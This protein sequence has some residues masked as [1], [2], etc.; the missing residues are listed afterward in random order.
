MIYVSNLAAGLEKSLDDPSFLL[1]SVSAF[2]GLAG[3]EFFMHAHDAAYR[4]KMHDVKNW[5][6]D[7]PRTVHGPFITVEATS[8]KG[9][10]A[11]EHFLSS[12]LWAFEEAERLG[13]REMVFHTHQRL[14]M[15]EEKAGLQIRC[16]QN[17]QTLIEKARPYGITIL[18]ENLGIQKQG[19][20]LF[21]EDEF[22]D[23]I[24]RYP[25]AGCLIDTGHLNVAGW[26]TEHVLASLGD[27]ILAYH[28]HNNDGISDSHLPIDCGTFSYPDFY[29]LYNRYTPNAH[30]TL[31]YGDG[32]AVT[33]EL[34]SRDVQSV[35]NGVQSAAAN[36]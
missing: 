27:R 9:T 13:C 17:L 4:Q 33:P 19:V 34:L 23:L 12:Y 22:I 1:R 35:L 31:E 28:L 3:I 11:Y 6:G 25:Q 8:E 10:E 24:R 14:I 32:E 29:R 18:I 15:P 20:N 2:D 36:K 7:L 30:L 5:L 26:N 16:E 21:D